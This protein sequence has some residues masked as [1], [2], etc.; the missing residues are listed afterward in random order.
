MRL[1]APG[2][3]LL[4][5]EYAVTEE[6]GLGLALA[7]EPGVLLSMEG[8]SS[9]TIEGSWGGGGLRWSRESAGGGLLVG[10]VVSTWEQLLQEGGRPAGAVA[11]LPGARIRIDSSR[12]YAGG[13][14]SGLGSSAAVAAALACALL[15]L[16]GFRGPE[17]TRMAC[18]VALEAHRRAQGGRGS[19]YDVYASVYGGFGC[20]IGGAEPVW[21]PVRLPWLPRLYLFRGREGVSTTDSLDR[22][23]RWKSAHP[24]E[25]R[26]FVE[27]SN[28]HLRAFLEAESWEQGRAHMTASR[29]LGLRLGEW[30]GV[31]ASMEA[32][33][34]CEPELCKAVGAG[35]ELGVYLGEAPPQGG[36]EPVA[37]CPEGVCWHT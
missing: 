28:R 35:N 8:S 37:I 10:S 7:V 32:P 9:L 2:N 24:G 29:R 30:I 19:G 1:S 20:L 27:E 25:A 5:G 13:R 11:G 31:P 33:P 6:G 23:R 4:L 18:R 17:L 15:R 34:G 12:L 26:R 36:L 3:L 21:Q 14:K 16:S 22:Y